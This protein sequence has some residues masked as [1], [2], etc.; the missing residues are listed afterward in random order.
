MIL[1]YFQILDSV[2][3]YLHFLKAVFQ[4]PRVPNAPLL[5]GKCANQA[6]KLIEIQ[7]F[8]IHELTTSHHYTNV[9]WDNVFIETERW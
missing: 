2:C 5:I 4:Y 1:W 3:Q 9:R 8:L 6:H 7:T